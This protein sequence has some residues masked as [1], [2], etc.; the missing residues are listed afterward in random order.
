MQEDDKIRATLL[1]QLRRKNIIGKK[2]TSFDNLKKGFPTHL[3]KDINKIAK[4]LIKE[5]WIITKPTSY[6]LEVSL[7]HSKIKEIENYILKSLNLSF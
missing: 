7:N 3:G 4:N 6:G 1:Y 5:D 2:H